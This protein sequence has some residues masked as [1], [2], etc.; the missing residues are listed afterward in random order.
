MVHNKASLEKACLEEA[1]KCFTQAAKS[2]I[3]QLPVTTG[4][5]NGGVGSMAFQQILAGMYDMIDI[6]N[7]YMVKLLSHIR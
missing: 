5:H 1:H 2:P 4:L 6:S 7:S 3:L